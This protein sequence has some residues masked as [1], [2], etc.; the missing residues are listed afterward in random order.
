MSTDSSQSKTSPTQSASSKKESS[1]P[2]KNPQ[3]TGTAR[4]VPFDETGGSGEV[5]ETS[6]PQKPPIDLDV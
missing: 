1:P 5:V 2:A 6:N 3:G 4:H